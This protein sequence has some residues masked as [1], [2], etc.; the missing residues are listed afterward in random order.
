MELEKKKNN[1]LEKISDIFLSEKKFEKV[2]VRDLNNFFNSSDSR[3]GIPK[4]HK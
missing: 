1:D 4:I 2:M 3:V